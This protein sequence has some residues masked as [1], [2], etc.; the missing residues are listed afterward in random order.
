MALFTDGP[1]SSIEDLTA[2]DSQLLSV[3]SVEGIDV[4]QKTVLAQEQVAME[5]IGALKRFGWA[6]SLLWQSPRPQ[7]DM[8]AVTQPLKLWHSALT[9]NL[10]YADAYNSQLNDR[11]A[12]RR[13]QFQELARWAYSKLIEIGLGIV[14]RPLPKPPVPTVT[15]F[16]G[17]LSDNLYYVAMAWVNQGG[18]EGTP[19]TATTIATTSSTF[20]VEPAPAPAAAAGW[21]VYIGLAPDTMYLQNS[22]LLPAGQTWQQ[23]VSLVQTGKLPGKGQMPDYLQPLPRILQRG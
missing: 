21:N 9:L 14:G 16:P 5:L 7:L 10:V 12:G 6:D 18:Q 20:L 2:Q 15:P 4:T 17:T 22:S 8:V 23:P 3:A 19:S 13:D 1:I 11:Y